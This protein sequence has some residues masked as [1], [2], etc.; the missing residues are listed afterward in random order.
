MVAESNAGDYSA[1][2]YQGAKLFRAVLTLISKSIC[3]RSI[4]IESIQLSVELVGLMGR[5]M[6]QSRAGIQYICVSFFDELPLLF[7]RIEMAWLQKYSYRGFG[8]KSSRSLCHKDQVR[9][10]SFRTLFASDSSCQYLASI[11]KVGK[12]LLFEP[13]KQ[14]VCL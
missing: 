4:F 7:N 2:N 9:S 8:I 6:S 14:F 3:L 12:F 5:A 1:L 11:I 10:P 13:S